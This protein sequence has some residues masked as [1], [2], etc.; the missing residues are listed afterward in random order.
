M[1]RDDPAVDLRADRAMAHVGVY[2]V[3]EVDRR[4]ARGQRLHLSLRREDVHLLVEDVH[5]EGLHE[6]PRIALVGVKVHQLLHP[7]DPLGVLR[8]A[9]AALVHPVRCDSELRLA[10]HLARAHLDLERP[11]LRTDHRRVQRAVAVELRHRDEILEPARHRLPQ[12]VDETERA[13]AVARPL[14]RAPLDGHAHRGEVVDLVELAA[15]LGHLV[16]DGIEVLRARGDLGGD[17]DLVEL[18]L[19]DARR[20]GDVLLAV[21]SPLRDHC[22]DLL[23]LARVQGLEGDV[24]ELPLERV[25]AEAMRERRV[26][27][28]RLLRLLHLLLLAEVLDLAQVVQ[29]V[30]ELDEDHA[31]V[32][33]HRHDQLAVVLRFG[34]LATLEVDARQLRNALDQ[35][36]DLVAEFLADVRD[37][38][39]RVL[40]DVVKQGGRDRLVVEPELRADLRRA[41]RMKH[42]LLARPALLALVGARGE[43][44]RPRDQIAVDFRVVRGDFGQQLVDELLMTLVSLDYCHIPIVRRGFSRSLGGASGATQVQETPFR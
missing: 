5:A 36:A 24:L 32:F 33:G 31:R 10:V 22:L 6:L 35:F 14:V 42:E 13:V 17:V 26:H 30:G 39:I 7:G 4:R 21:R 41:P 1:Q 15:L 8:A 25:D 28:E 23:V 20:L 9:L 11:P 37:V 18:E 16:V 2:R 19:Q 34:L 40:D 3:G 43:P 12:R 27:L 38:R 44:E 29:A